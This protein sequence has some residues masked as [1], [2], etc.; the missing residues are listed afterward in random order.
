MYPFLRMERKESVPIIAITGG[1]CAGK[2]TVLQAIASEYGTA[3]TFAKEAATILFEGGF[4]QPGKDMEYSDE[5]HYHFQSSVLELQLHYEELSAS[6]AR[7]IGA[8]AVVTDRG[9]PDSLAYTPGGADE[10]HLRYGID[11]CNEY[12]RYAHVIHLESLA[13]ADPDRYGKENNPYRYEE[14][15]Q[16]AILEE[17]VRDAWS[18][19]PSRTI[20]EGSN[21]SE[22]IRVVR[23]VVGRLLAGTERNEVSSVEPTRW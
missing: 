8:L 21:I 18:G 12:A 9:R 15:A 1:P 14:L 5:W 22:K 11:L 16:A 20:V 3:I 2:T 19:H 10:F 13:T 7:R 23:R 17:A 4:P 6:Y